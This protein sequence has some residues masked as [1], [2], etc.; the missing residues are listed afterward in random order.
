MNND[1]S[2][3]I[4]GKT[5]NGL[6]ERYYDELSEI[7]FEREVIEKM[8]VEA[9]FSVEAVYDFDTVNPPMVNSEKL[10]FVARKS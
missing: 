7:A 9:G 8:L 2:L 6:F 4:F 1:I 10:V 3:D 5:E